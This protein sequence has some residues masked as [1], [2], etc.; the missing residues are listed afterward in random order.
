MTL[1]VV[2]DTNIIISGSFWKGPPHTVVQTIWSGDVI[3]LATS[4]MITEL[5][6]TLAREKF[7]AYAVK[8]NQSIDELIDT[9]AAIALVVEP[10][11]VPPNVVRD[12]KDQMLLACAVGGRADAVVSGDKDLLVLGS[13]EG[14]PIWSVTEFLAKRQSD[15]G[16][17]EPS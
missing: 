10:I 15:E 2:V 6:T 12:P 8:A 9:Y 4:A 16:H 5:R 11:S 1:R 13:Y 7:A 14:I 3:P 17:S